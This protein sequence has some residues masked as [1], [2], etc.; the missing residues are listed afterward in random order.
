MKPR[1]LA[2]KCVLRFSLLIRPS[3]L[4]PLTQ[5]CLFVGFWFQ[6]VIRI[7]SVV[8]KSSL[9][10]AYDKLFL[11]VTCRLARLARMMVSS[12]CFPHILPSDT[13]RSNSLHLFL[14]FFRRTF[15]LVN[16]QERGVRS[17]SLPTCPTITACETDLLATNQCSRR[18]PPPLHVQI[19]VPYNPY[20]TFPHPSRPRVNINCMRFFYTCS[21]RTTLALT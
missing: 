7:D 20:A 16:G 21:A 17:S 10:Y 11:L 14:L 13:N 2:I 15:F 6:L 8:D 5:I 9:K 1:R 12:K 3:S 18:L 4:I 19:V